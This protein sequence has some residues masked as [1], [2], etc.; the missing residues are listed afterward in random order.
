MADLVDLAARSAKMESDR[1]DPL[2]RVPTPNNQN[3]D[4]ENNLLEFATNHHSFDR[5]GC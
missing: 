1:P 3:Y 4:R 5:V 2:A